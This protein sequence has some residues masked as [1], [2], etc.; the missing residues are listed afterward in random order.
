MTF[1]P[2][3]VDQDGKIRISNGGTK[4]DDTQYYVP[5][6]KTDQYEVRCITVNYMVKVTID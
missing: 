5:N 6:N 3:D 2:K 1:D 4:D